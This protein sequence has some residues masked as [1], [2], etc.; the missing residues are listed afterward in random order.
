LYLEKLKNIKAEDVSDGK[1]I[2]KTTKRL[3]TKEDEG[4]ANSRMRLFTVEPGGHTPWHKH[5][6]EHE[7]YFVKGKGV[8]VTEDKE[9]EVEAGMFGYVDS[10]EMH[11]FKNPYDE[12]FEFICLIPISN[13]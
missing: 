4:L 8:L 11:Q 7:N 13:E 6:W 2:K 5:N 10:E 3:L 1:E 12:A 9:L